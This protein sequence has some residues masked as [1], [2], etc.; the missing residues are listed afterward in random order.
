MYKNY[1]EYVRDRWNMEHII[2]IVNAKPNIKGFHGLHN[3]YCR[4]L[5]HYLGNF[6]ASECI[7]I[8]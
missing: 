7:S 1:Q 5:E 2:I 8:Q 3:T 4:K 6:Y